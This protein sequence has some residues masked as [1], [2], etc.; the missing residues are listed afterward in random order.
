MPPLTASS[1][2]TSAVIGGALRTTSTK[3]LRLSGGREP[4]WAWASGSSTLTISGV[5]CVR[6]SIASP[7]RTTLASQ[8]TVWSAAGSRT[9]AFRSVTAPLGSRRTSGPTWP[10]GNCAAISTASVPSAVI[11]TWPRLTTWPSSAATSVRRTS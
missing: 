2:T 4:A 11:I 5:L 10:M 3:V 9:L 1:G 8:L 6:A 7:A